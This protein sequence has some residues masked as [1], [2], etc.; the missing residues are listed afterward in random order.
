MVDPRNLLAIEDLA[1][2]TDRSIVPVIVTRED[3]D[4][5]FRRLGHDGD[6]LASEADIEADAEIARQATLEQA[7]DDGPTVKLVRSIIAEAVERRASD[8][9][10]IPRTPACSSACGDNRL[11]PPSLPPR[12]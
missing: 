5:L 8:I 1:M 11:R 4:S 12:R 6:Q 7:A 3:L 2:P 10:S 9:H